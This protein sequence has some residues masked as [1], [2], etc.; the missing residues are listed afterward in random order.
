MSSRS[1]SKSQ[2]PIVSVQVLMLL[3]DVDVDAPWCPVGQCP[4]VS[5]LTSFPGLDYQLSPRH[6]RLPHVTVRRTRADQTVT[7]C[8]DLAVSISIVLPLTDSECL[9]SDYKSSFA[10]WLY[11]FVL[12]LVMIPGTRDT[13]GMSTNP[14]EVILLSFDFDVNQLVSSEKSLGKIFNRPHAVLRPCFYLCYQQVPEF[15]SIPASDFSPRVFS[16]YRIKAKE[17]KQF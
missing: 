13:I 9:E 17:K 16:N 3:V 8:P 4:S 14:I 2:C 10:E 7:F 1:V 11:P 6:C 12:F 5:A 15:V